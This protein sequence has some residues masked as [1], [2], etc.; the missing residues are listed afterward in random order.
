MSDFYGT[1]MNEGNAKYQYPIVIENVPTKPMIFRIFSQDMNDGSYP[2][3]YY[4]SHIKLADTGALRKENNELKKV[5]GKLIPGIDK[6]KKYVL[7]SAFN[8]L[9]SPGR[10]AQSFDVTD[11]L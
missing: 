11:K 4:V 2:M 1:I 6:D 9:P 7:Y 8:Q 3:V 5:I 10:Y